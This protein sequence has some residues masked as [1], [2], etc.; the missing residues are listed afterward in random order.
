MF[1]SIEE[2]KRANR[3]FG[4][5]FFDADTMRFF[6]S[7]V[8]ADLYV[9]KGEEQGEDVTYFITS[10]RNGDGPRLYMVR[11]VLDNGLVSSASEFQQ[12]ETLNKARKLARLL[13]GEDQKNYRWIVYMYTAQGSFDVVRVE[14]LLD[15]ERALIAYGYATYEY[16]RVTASLYPYSA[17]NWADAEDFRDSGCP[18]DYP[19]KTIEFGPRGGAR[20]T[21]A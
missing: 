11:Y 18:L 17:E 13:A 9:R 21:N 12:C 6:N 16:E 8:Y 7:R 14:T 4:Q 5:H 1:H 3:A 15:A 2:I 19:S 10:E 20:I